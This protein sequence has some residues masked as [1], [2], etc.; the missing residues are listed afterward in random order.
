M[1]HS[2][3]PSSCRMT[4]SWAKPVPLG[5]GACDPLLVCRGSR[6]EIDDPLLLLEGFGAEISAAMLVEPAVHLLTPCC[7]L[8]LCSVGEGQGGHRGLRQGDLHPAVGLTCAHSG[9]RR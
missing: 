2:S 3:L 6:Q 5:V 4:K 8:R 7:A 1:G 9:P